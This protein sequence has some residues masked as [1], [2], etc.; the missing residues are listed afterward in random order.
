MEVR[1]VEV[2]HGV[3]KSSSIGGVNTAEPQRDVGFG[4]V[5]CAA[6][7]QVAVLRITFLS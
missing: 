1:V 6:V 4:R 7:K 2:G 5:R 3:W